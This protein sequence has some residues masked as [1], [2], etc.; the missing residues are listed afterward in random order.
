MPEDSE[1]FSS[2][3]PTIRFL[4][5]HCNDLTAT[6]KFYSEMVGLKEKA[7]S[8]DC[9][10]LCYQCDGFEF[11]FFKSSG[12]GL[13]IETRWA[14]QPGYPGGE[15]E[16]ISWAI[17]VPEGDFRAMLKRLMEGGV[18]LLANK[19]EWR[20]ECY[21]GITAMDPNGVTVEIYFTPAE[22]PQL[23]EWSD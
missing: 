9:G 14:L 23:T 6:R 13:P 4:F 15:L 7:Y 20:Q 16:T 17:I 2:R 18:R 22:K 1:N 11:M 12:G 8:E 5:N 3:T 21:W 10:Y 19:P